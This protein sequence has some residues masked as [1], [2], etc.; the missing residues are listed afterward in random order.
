MAYLKSYYEL[1]A[2]WTALDVFYDLQ[3]RRYHVQNLDNEESG[4][5]DYSQAAPDD[6]YFK[7]AAL[8]RRGVR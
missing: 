8:R 6:N 3:S 7:P 5:I 2:I 4:T 1:P